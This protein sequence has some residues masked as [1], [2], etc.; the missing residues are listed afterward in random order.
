MRLFVLYL[1]LIPH[2]WDLLLEGVGSWILIGD[3]CTHLVLEDVQVEVEGRLLLVVSQTTVL[4]AEALKDI[5]HV[6]GLDLVE[7]GI[8]D[9]I[10]RLRVQVLPRD[11]PA[12]VLDVVDKAVDFDATRD[13]RLL[14]ATNLRLQDLQL[15]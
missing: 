2:L 5:L 3:L 9:C 12:P 15:L 6:V 4:A 8:D 11:D 7:D 1:Q 10:G 13:D 14:T